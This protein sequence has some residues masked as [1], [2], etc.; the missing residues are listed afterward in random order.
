M[1]E[2]LL[3]IFVPWWHDKCNRWVGQD[4]CVPNVCSP[5]DVDKDQVRYTSF[6]GLTFTNSC[7][8]SKELSVRVKMSLFEINL[9]LLQYEILEKLVT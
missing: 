5:F 3:I 6:Q 1:L 8:T 7:T 2:T 9:K 4:L